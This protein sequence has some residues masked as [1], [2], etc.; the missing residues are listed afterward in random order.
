M[1]K[2]KIM[3]ELE[4]ETLRWKTITKQSN[5]KLLEI[6][7]MQKQAVKEFNEALAYR[8]NN[9]DPESKLNNN[10]ILKAASDKLLEISLKRKQIV[11]EFNT[12]RADRDAA[13]F[14]L[15]PNY[16]VKTVNADVMIFNNF[17]IKNCSLNEMLDN[18]YKNK[19]IP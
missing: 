8:D 3:T 2:Y 15:N 17:D 10:I 18:Y 13:L 4:E 12:F 7:V 6:S 9:P 16:I 1:C 14:R 19:T 5:D 11:R